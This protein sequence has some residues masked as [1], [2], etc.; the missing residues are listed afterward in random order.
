MISGTTLAGALRAS[1]ADQDP[2]AAVS[3]FGS[4]TS[5]NQSRESWVQVGDAYLENLTDTP[6]TETRDGV[7]IDGI[8]RTASPRLKYDLELLEAGVRFRFDITLLLP[9]GHP[10][11]EADFK[12]ALKGLDGSIR[13]GRRKRRGYGK[14][15]IAW[16]KI[17]RYQFPID[18]VR[19][20]ENPLSEAEGEFTTLD[21]SQIPAPAVSRVKD[22]VV[23]LT[24]T[25]DSSL[26]VRSAPIE[27]Q[28]GVKNL[29]DQEMIRSKRKVL[30]NGREMIEACPILPGTSLAGALRARTERIANT[31]RPGSGKVWAAQL[32]GQSREFGELTASRMWVDETVIEAPNEWIHT[33]VK[34]DR[35]TGGAYPG[36]LFSEGV[37][38]PSPATRLT[39]HLRLQEADEG[40]VGMLLLLLKDLWTGDLPLGGEAGAGRGRLRGQTVDIQWK[41]HTWRLADQGEG[42]LQ[43][44]ASP[45]AIDLDTLVQ[46]IGDVI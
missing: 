26:L 8:T 31:L 44:E 19:W 41:G 39:I 36:A 5:G 27:V 29:P 28:P 7:G 14:C 38:L 34:I 4:V 25:L 33:K 3:L 22:C 20:L 6:R 43:I 35:F 2:Q 45:N 12:R 32:F 37:L 42:S 9:V 13:L 46:A 21:L 23:D 15:H 11:Y 40:E 30:R 17:W 10:G 1:L 16:T 24:C 18:L